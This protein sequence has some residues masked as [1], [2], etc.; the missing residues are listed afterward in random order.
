VLK[1]PETIRVRGHEGLALNLWDYGGDG[2]PV[3]L[4]HCTGGC[5]RLW[6]PV[7][8]RLR[9]SR[10]VYALDTRG[11]GESEKPMTRG[12][13]EWR[14]AGLDL[15]AVADRLGYGAELV[16]VGHSG[17]GAQAAYAAWL[18]PGVFARA[19]W[20]DAIVGP[21]AFFAGESVLAR[22]ARRR[23]RVFEDRNTAL[24]RFSAKAPMNSWTHETLKAY[25][26]Y[27][28]GDGAD[29]RVEL[30]CPPAAEA[31]MYELGGA[32]EVFERLED[33]Q[34]DLLLI[35]G[36]RSG[37][38]PLVLAQYE[39]LPRALMAEMADTGHFIPQE[40]PGELAEL[41]LSWL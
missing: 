6:D 36:T 23:A 35:T 13:Y 8:A 27:G 1:Q 15:L 3:L 25:V 40:R 30:K 38:K 28:L 19:A 11:H 5:G 29:G 16:V 34:A 18:R 2:P 4:L 20:I 7:A 17:G 22:T 12:A 31:W 32:C 10:R 21:R 41:L 33:V 39:K 26:E 24:R 14:L 9:P 37:I